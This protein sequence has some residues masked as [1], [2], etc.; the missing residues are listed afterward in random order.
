MHDAEEDPLFKCW[1]GRSNILREENALSPT[2]KPVLGT[3]HQCWNQ[4]WKPHWNQ[5]RFQNI[6]NHHF[7]NVGCD[8]P[9]CFMR[10][11]R[12]PQHWTLKRNIFVKIFH[13]DAWC[14]SRPTFQ[15]LVMTIQYASWGKY[16]IPNTQTS[17]VFEVLKYWNI[18]K[19]AKISGLNPASGFPWFIVDLWALSHV[20]W[21][22]MSKTWS[23]KLER[24]KGDCMQLVW[25]L[26]P[27]YPA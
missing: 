25:A 2:L 10:K 15:M 8:D 21:S 24:F 13:S 11:M 1:L 7:S 6:W 17:V 9:I 20:S 14:W 19:I 5:C 23:D 26:L 27:L 3:A 16:A 4:C 22:L 12:C 18:L